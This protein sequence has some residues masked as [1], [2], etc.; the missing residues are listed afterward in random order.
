MGEFTHSPFD[1]QANSLIG[2]PL[3]RPTVALTY[4]QVTRMRPSGMQ[5]GA[6]IILLKPSNV[7]R[8][9]HVI[10]IGSFEDSQ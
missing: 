7:L 6:H 3:A 4:R 1:L 8:D 5:V 10:S 9:R 2:E